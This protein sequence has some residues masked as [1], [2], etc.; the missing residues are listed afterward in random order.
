MSDLHATVEHGHAA[1]AQIAASAVAEHG[2]LTGTCANCTTPTI[3]AYC[4]VCGQE[5]DTHRRSVLGLVRDLVEDIASFDSRIL[6]TAIAL[7]VEPGE[8]PTAFREGRTQRYVPALR[9]YFFVSLVFFL[10]LSMTGLAIL[11]LEVVGAPMKVNIVNGHYYF[12]N[13]AYDPDDSDNK[14]LPKQIEISKA[15]ATQPGGPLSF[16]TQ[17]HFFARIGAFHSHLTAAQQQQLLHP[18]INFNI[19]VQ[20]GAN[21]KADAKKTR[22]TKSWIEKN[23]FVGVK[24]LAA[25]PAALNGPMTTWIPRMLFLLLPLYALLLFLHYW[26]QH[27]KFYFVD[28]LIFSLSIHTFLFVVLITDAGL[29][30]FMSG[31]NVAWLTFAVMSLYIFIAMKRFYEQS[32]FWTTVKFFSVSFFYTSFCLFP[33]MIGVLMLSFLGDSIG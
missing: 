12:T 27:Q 18:N 6:R 22:E 21:A 17:A 29:A 24:R 3:G 5:R 20:G 7:L 10:I 26:R 2:H 9:L 11:Q 30:Q 15:K 25:D 33:A 1:A 32:W 16:S 4:V 13:P 28:H 23:V 14:L 19:N 8:I 31:E